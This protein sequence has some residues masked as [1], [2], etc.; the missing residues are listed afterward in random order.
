MTTGYVFKAGKQTAISND[1][2]GSNL[3]APKQDAWKLEKT[4]D[5]VNKPGLIGFDPVAF[6]KQGFQ[7]VGQ[8]GGVLGEENVLDDPNILQSK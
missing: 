4:V 1:P 6:E 8:S 3:P 2:T 7:I 5:D